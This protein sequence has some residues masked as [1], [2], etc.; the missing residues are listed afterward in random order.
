M[1]LD[2]WV[3]VAAIVG[4]LSTGL[5]G[6]VIIATAVIYG[7][8]LRAIRRANVLESMLV[9]LRYIEDA[10]L[11][12]ARWFL[13]L[14]PEILRDLPEMPITEGWANLNER[15]QQ[16]SGGKC[17][18]HQIDL[19]INTLNDIAYLINTKHIPANVV[20]DFLRHTFQRC[21]SL[22]EE[23]ID[24]RR[25]HPLDYQGR[26]SVQSKYAYHLQGLVER[27]E[28]KSIDSN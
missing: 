7:L 1:D 12:R 8:Q 5:A 27:L 14:H 10:E 18:L 3:K 17:D 9:V 28:G 13:Y 19:V 2:W 4:G 15:V 26:Q 24:Y 11:R 23:Y 22:Y 21:W 6:M 16:A 25:K 20:D